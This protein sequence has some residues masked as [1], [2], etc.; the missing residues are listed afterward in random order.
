DSA[1]FAPD[2]AAATPAGGLPARRAYVKRPAARKVSLRGMTGAATAAI[3]TIGNEIVSGDVANTNGSWLAQRLAQLGLS[4]HLL[5]AVPDDIDLVGEF[6]RREAPRAEVVVVTGGL[7]GT[8]D[9]I[10]REALAAA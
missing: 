10:T 3:L 5:A 4:A 9:D 1:G 2:F 6:L 7:G 8:P